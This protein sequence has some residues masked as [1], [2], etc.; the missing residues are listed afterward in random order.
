MVYPPDTQMTARFLFQ[1]NRVEAKGPQ[2]LDDCVFARGQYPG[3]YSNGCGLLSLDGQRA[4]WKGFVSIAASRLKQ[5]ILGGQ[6]Q[7]IAVRNVEGWQIMSEGKHGQ[8]KHERPEYRGKSG[9][10]FVWF[11]VSH[12]S[13]KGSGT[14]AVA[15]IA[16]VF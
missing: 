3:G 16:P 13:Q 11:V 6:S 7:N 10:P 8:R 14:N 9:R 2:L 5:V 12:L 1:L 15:L 4:K